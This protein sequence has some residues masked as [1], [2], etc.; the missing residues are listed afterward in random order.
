[1]KAT[2]APSLWP[3]FVSGRS[4]VLNRTRYVSLRQ[5]AA[6]LGIPYDG[7]FHHY[8]MGRIPGQKVGTVVLVEV[9][10]VKAVLESVG[11]T[12]RRKVNQS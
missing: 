3:I 1:M 10:V 4:E 2:D 11:Y 6:E 9:P 12:P 8:R 5:A 7:L